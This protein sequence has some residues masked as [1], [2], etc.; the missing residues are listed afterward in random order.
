M[1]L[2][3][4]NITKSEI[5]GIYLSEIFSLS[6]SIKR[7]CEEIFEKTKIPD[8][9]YLIQVSS[10]IH[11]LINNVIINAANIKKLICSP[12]PRQKKESAK[13]FKVRK[14]REALFQ[15][16]LSGLDTHE[17]Y[18]TDVRNKLEHFDEYLD[19]MALKL[20]D[21]KSDIKN[22]YPAASYKMF[23]SDWEVFK[24]HVYPIRLYITSEK[25]F[26]HMKWSVSIKN[27]YDES[28]EIIN[29]LEKLKLIHNE[30]ELGGSLVVFKK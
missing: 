12:L 15:E 4:I 14:Q 28:I 8:K 25:T 5:M 18:N 13:N 16:I 9:G 27:L 21:E 11:S 2:E 1:N 23:F 29:R 22:D 24:P 19:S 3:E 17:I 26:Y 10:E 20:M 7:D 6:F 30:N